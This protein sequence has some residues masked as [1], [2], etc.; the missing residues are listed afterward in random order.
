MSEQEFED[1]FKKR[2]SNFEADPGKEAWANLQK[3]MSQSAISSTSYRVAAL[4]L[5]LIL[6]LPFGIWISREPVNDQEGVKQVRKPLTANEPAKEQH[7]PAPPE[8]VEDSDLQQNQSGIYSKKDDP[9]TP[10]NEVGLIIPSSREDLVLLNHSKKNSP[11][12]RLIP[13]KPYFKTTNPGFITQISGSKQL[14]SG[15]VI[16]KPARIL[17]IYLNAMPVWSYGIVTPA[18]NDVWD[19]KPEQQAALSGS[20]LGV[21]S[22]L[23]VEIPLN[24]RLSLNAG[25]A[26]QFLQLPLFYNQLSV[27]EYV[28]TVEESVMRLTPV[29]DQENTR[30]MIRAHRAGVQMQLNYLLSTGNVKTYISGGGNYQIGFGQAMDAAFLDLGFRID[31]PVNQRLTLKMEPGIQYQIN[32]NFDLSVLQYKTYQWGLD[33]GLIYQLPYK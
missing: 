19:I 28:T 20:R 24:S 14:N 18:L 7:D 15:Q 25:L 12:T 16:I 21:F 13:I 29:F 22:T 11:N 4:F 2:F 32:Q 33:F 31:L 1:Q 23:G 5:L 17:R 9:E 27:K 26:Y 30:D 3:G 6:G 8:E 10:E